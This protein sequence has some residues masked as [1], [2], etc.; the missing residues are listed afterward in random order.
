MRK[1]AAVALLLVFSG[2]K[3]GSAKVIHAG[4]HAVVLPEGVLEFGTV[5]VNARAVKPISVQND[6]NHELTVTP[7]LTGDAAFGGDFAE[8][9]SFK[10]QAGE[11]VLLQMQYIPSAI[12]QN[13]GTV[14]LLTDSEGTP[15]FSVALHGKAVSST[16]QI[17]SG[18][19]CDDGAHLAVDFGQ[20]QPGIGVDKELV[21]RVQGD[22]PI[23]IPRITLTAQTDP[24]YAVKGI[25]AQMP[26]ELA[27]GQEL[28]LT[29]TYKP[30]Q[31]GPAP[32]QLE[33]LSNSDGQP[34][35]LV[36]LTGQGIA[37]RLCIDKADLDFGDV[38]LSQTAHKT[39]TLRSCGLLP[40]RLDSLSTASPFGLTA[41]ALPQTLQPGATLPLPLSFAPPTVGLQQQ[42]LSVAS[43]E[44]R[45]GGFTLSGEG[46]QCI[47]D[48]SPG[49]L[50]FGQVST[51]VK[52]AKTFYLRSVGYSDCTVTA[53]SSPGS[54]FTVPAP[55]QLPLLLPVGV[56]LPVEVDFQPAAQGAASGSISVVS[57]D[58]TL[59]TQVE[60][61]Q[62]QGIA[63]P[64]CDFTAVPFSVAFGAVDVGKSST[65]PVAV[66]NHGS[67]ECYITGGG[68]S[69]DPSFS[70][71][72]PSGFPPPSLLPGASVT[73]PV[74]YT[75]ASSA[76]HSGTLT[77][78]Y[79]KDQVA[80]SGAQ[81]LTVPLQGGTLTP[82]LCVTPTLL[83]Y[84]S[85]AAGSRAIKSFILSSCGD[86]TLTVRGI[87][88]KT[89]TSAEFSLTAAPAMPLELAKGSSATINVQYQPISA[90][91]AGGAIEIYS[92]DPAALT[93]R[94][95]LKGNGGSCAAQLIC[96]PAQVDFT[97]TMVGRT[98]AQ[99]VT[100]LA[101]GGA[102]TVSAITASAGASP[103]LSMQAGQ[104]PKTL[105]DGDALRAEVQF[106]PSSASAGVATFTFQTGGCGNGKVDVTAIGQPSKVPACPAVAAFTPKTKWA[107]NGG[108]RL[109]SWSNVTMTPAVANLDDDNG[110]G[111]VDENDIPDVVF[112]SCS[113]GSC[114]VNCA[115]PKHMENAD[116]SG[117]AVLRAVSGKD[118][119]ERW[120]AD[121]AALHVPAGA[122]LAVADINNDG[123]PEIIAV[124]HSF[125]PG[126]TCPGQPVDSLPMCSKYITGNL[127]V[128]D[129]FGKL[130]FMS[131]PWT[132]PPTVVENDSS[133]LVADL[134]QDGFPEIIYGDTVF[135]STGH[136]K[137]HMSG[138]TGNTGHGTFAAA[139]DVDGDGKLELLAG[140]TAYRADGTVLWTTPH[141]D[142][143]ITLVMDV[144]GDGKPEVVV[145]PTASHVI[146][147][148]GATGSIKRDLQLAVGADQ[149]GIDASA[150]PSGP[151]AADF[152]GN[153]RMQLAMAAGNWFYLIRL[154]TGETL[155]R[156]PIEDYQGQ[157]GASGAA[158]FSFFGDGKND[159]VYHDSQNIF[160]WRADG[161]EVYKAPRNSSTLFETPVIADVDN[162]GH[163]DVLI[164]NQGLGGTNN[165]LT[166]LSDSGNSW[167]A[168]RRVW[169]QWNYHV[170]DANE[171][172]TVP[173]VEQPFWKT[174]RLWRGNP[175]LCKQ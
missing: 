92:N 41:P 56:E 32:G 49:T 161:T 147:L 33:V 14:T 171:N 67:Q 62:G 154:D 13:N 47:L 16:L 113:S 86:G 141:V 160:V 152:L 75:P 175:P 80:I 27:V 1:Q 102:L 101:S 35:K 107:W 114:C 120:T 12:G 10:V 143:G 38:Q 54:G 15:K 71:T 9:Q 134:D 157:C 87:Q 46:V 6:G 31:G 73:I 97:G 137:W 5:R 151:S 7:A 128:L 122:Q 158:V 40:L 108:T 50:D 4:P 168:T 165:G 44:L 57:D 52:A 159:I 172:A 131:E 25:P 99:P 145:R 170:T 135:D 24:G 17:C 136:V 169:T 140:P 59:A 36:D 149:G 8:G 28:H 63:P 81:T 111:R 60:H 45:P 105:Q 85:V 88:P 98:S 84:G 23:D 144:D 19:A 72:M 124:Q 104:L 90:S 150:C 39:A 129:R 68:A 163:A 61:L 118:G 11:T 30:V 26:V 43:N 173:R 21:L 162:D 95:Q 64:P 20:V 110:D 78:K 29:V 123:E 164:T 66:T 139:A 119:S 93:S 18:A 77:V 55:P 117:E 148:D 79:N 82:K 132:Q 167:P 127:L 2:C 91:P 116:L 121:A 112:A 130:L 53:I 89:G 76:V 155:W 106:A 133:L 69:G 70:A 174:S 156:K 100:C 96:T 103:D 74:K 48:L 115:D 142:D 146:V 125:R 58:S 34:R 42:A 65:V 166:A 153:G 138:T 109:S 126:Q 94:V 51:S 3:C 22:A 83:D 37:P